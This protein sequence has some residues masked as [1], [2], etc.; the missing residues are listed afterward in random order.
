MESSSFIGQVNEVEHL[1]MYLYF[2][3]LEP[4]LDYSEQEKESF[5]KAYDEFE[6]QLK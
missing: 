6:N 3:N 1:W 5:L 2:L 4:D